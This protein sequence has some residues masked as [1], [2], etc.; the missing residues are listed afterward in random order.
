MRSPLR[1][2]V[3][4]RKKLRRF[5]AVGSK[6]TSASNRVP[7]FLRNRFGLSN[8]A[9]VLTVPH[10]VEEDAGLGCRPNCAHHHHERNH[11]GLD[12]VIPFP[13]RRSEPG[14][15]KIIKSARLAGCSISTIA[16]RRNPP[17]SIRWHT[18]SASFS[19][20]EASVRI[21]PSGLQ[22]GPPGPFFCLAA[23]EIFALN[24]T[25]A[26]DLLPILLG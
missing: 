8:W 11:Q 12:D 23:N 26:T 18:G 24:F 20:W 22:P 21:G 9:R 19:G 4:G 6:N 1:N 13:D 16:P 14:N 10:A 17:P 15:G 2:Q 3:K 5:L 7:D 25:R